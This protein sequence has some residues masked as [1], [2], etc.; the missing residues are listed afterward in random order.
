MSWGNWGSG[1]YSPNWYYSARY[2]RSF[3]HYN[4][5]YTYPSAYLSVGNFGLPYYSTYCPTYYQTLPMSSFYY[6]PQSYYG[7]PLGV[8]NYSPAAYLDPLQLGAVSRTTYS[9]LRPTVYSALRPTVDSS[10][11]Y[12]SLIDGGESRPISESSLSS[13]STGSYSTPAYSAEAA[14]DGQLITTGRIEGVIP[15]RLLAAAD[16]ILKAGGSRQAAAAYA[17]LQVRYGPSDMIFGRRF[18][19]QVDS[20]DLNQALV[21]LESAMAAGYRIRREDVPSEGVNAL[22][23]PALS[24]MAPPAEALAEFALERPEE[25]MPLRMIATWLELSGD[26]A[27]ARMFTERA[28]QLARESMGGSEAAPT[29]KF[30]KVE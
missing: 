1:L 24:S 23:A 11:I 17:Q 21:V 6:A 26:E 8:S 27:R 9:T 19:A 3:Y 5:G 4:Y 25:A 28:D 12:G 10:G 30:V 16:A 14:T 2:P 29:S 18:I 20:D 7:L 13:Y 22:L 15:D